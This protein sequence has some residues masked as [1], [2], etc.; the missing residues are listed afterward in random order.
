VIYLHRMGMIMGSMLRRYYFQVYDEAMDGGI[1]RV[2]ELP[3]AWDEFSDR[4]SEIQEQIH[5]GRA[6][7]ELSS[8]YME[9]MRM[10][11]GLLR[12]TL[13]DWGE[14]HPLYEGFAETFFRGLENEDG[15]RELLDRMLEVSR[16]LQSDRRLQRHGQ[17]P[18]A[19]PM[20]WISEG[21]GE[22]QT[23]LDPTS[24]FFAS[25]PDSIRDLVFGD[26]EFLGHQF[27][28]TPE[29]ALAHRLVEV[30]AADQGRAES[31]EIL[32]RGH[33]VHELH[34]AAQWIRSKMV[35]LYHRNRNFY[36]RLLEYY[37]DGL[38]EASLLPL[39]GDMQQLPRV[40]TGSLTWN[41][42]RDLG[43][44]TPRAELHTRGAAIGFVLRLSMMEMLQFG[45]SRGLFDLE[46]QGLDRQSLQNYLE[47][48]GRSGGP[49]DF[50]EAHLQAIGDLDRF[51]LRV[52]YQWGNYHPLVQGFY[53]NFPEHDILG[54][55][56][57]QL[58]ALRQEVED[59]LRSREEPH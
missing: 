31:Q 34:R 43:A 5:R 26:L 48:T 50:T 1:V 27:A 21:E 14:L 23:F 18:E 13:N 47:T 45:E 40:L 9:R 6:R 59:Y 39:I 19:P 41:P 10:V 3:W 33:T 12:Q 7:L 15:N 32:E 56:S 24:S 25:M 4:W 29:Y 46:G 55:H 28:A 49:G 30:V 35:E 51:I 11:E 22:G 57:R 42:A 36:D 38:S 16:N 52:H 8:T 44:D 2:S 20:G 58:R 54:P 17:F 53:E 37:L